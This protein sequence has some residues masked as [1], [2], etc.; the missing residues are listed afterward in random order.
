MRRK[1]KTWLINSI[2]NSVKISSLPVFLSVNKAITLQLMRV[3]VTL[4]SHLLWKTNMHF[5]RYWMFHVKLVVPL[6]S[7]IKCFFQPLERDARVSQ[8]LFLL[9]AM[10]T[11]TQNNIKSILVITLRVL[12]MNTDEYCFVSVQY[13]HHHKLK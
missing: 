9:M 8:W 7:I 13:V 11:I 10:Q 4:S 6:N 3:A 1:Q 5:W 2:Q 12:K